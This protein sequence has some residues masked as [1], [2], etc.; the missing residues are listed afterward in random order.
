MD[1]DPTDQV[2]IVGCL[3]IGF[4]LIASSIYYVVS[5]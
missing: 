3:L 2:I 5:S 4:W 1:G